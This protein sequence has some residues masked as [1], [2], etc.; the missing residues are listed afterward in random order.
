MLLSQGGATNLKGGR[1]N[2]LEGGVVNSVK[3][4]TFFK[5]GG[6]MTPPQ[7]LWWRRPCSVEHKHKMASMIVEIPIVRQL[8]LYWSKEASRSVQNVKFLFHR[9]SLLQLNITIHT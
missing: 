6:C 4:L 9:S 7:L 5:C 8:N 2:V 1:V 3:T